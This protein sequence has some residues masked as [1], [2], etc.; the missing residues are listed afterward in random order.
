MDSTKLFLRR[1]SGK[2]RQQNMSILTPS[3][4]RQSAME[5]RSFH[6]PDRKQEVWIQATAA[7]RIIWPMLLPSL[8]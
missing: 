2:F 8:K 1:E 5:G 4:A 6:S 3:N 7:S